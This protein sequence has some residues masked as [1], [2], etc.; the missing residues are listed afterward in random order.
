MANDTLLAFEQVDVELY[1]ADSGP[2]LRKISTAWPNPWV[3]LIWALDAPQKNFVLP[4]RKPEEEEFFFSDDGKLAL[5]TMETVS[6]E[7][8]RW[9]IYGPDFRVDIS[10]AGADDGRNRVWIVT[11]LSIE[12]NPPWAKLLEQQRKRLGE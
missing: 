10:A 12:G 4:K 8:K 3:R 5:G 9:V 1:M 2:R 6:A 7:P 11:N